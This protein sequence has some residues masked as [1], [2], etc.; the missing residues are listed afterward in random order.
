LLG[1]YVLT[2][3]TPE[4]NRLWITSHAWWEAIEM[5]IGVSNARTVAANTGIMDI[6]P[7]GR[8][9][10]NGVHYRARVLLTSAA[11]RAAWTP[12]QRWPSR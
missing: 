12:A 5:V 10:P 4:A 3:D 6:K 8:C 1:F 9:Y 7:N 2:A 11:R